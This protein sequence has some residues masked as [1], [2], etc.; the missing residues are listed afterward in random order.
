ML[1]KD[2]LN[3]ELVRVEYS[4]GSTI[5]INYNPETDKTYNGITVPAKS[6]VVVKGGTN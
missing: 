2:I 6:Y 1:K 5:L 4:N 3:Y